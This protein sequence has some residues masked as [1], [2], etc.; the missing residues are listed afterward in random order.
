LKY[1]D[2]SEETTAAISGSKSKQSKHPAR[3]KFF[4]LVTSLLFFLEDEGELLSDY[5]ASHAGRQ[6]ST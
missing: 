4:L 5:T 1:I 6:Y 3:R 2:V